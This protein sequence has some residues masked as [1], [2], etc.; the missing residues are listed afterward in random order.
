[1]AIR[2]PLVTISGQLQELPSGDTVAGSGG[3][4]VVSTLSINVPDV[5]DG[6]FEWIES[7]PGL[8][9][10]K[11]AVAWFAESDSFPLDILRFFRVQAACEVAGQLRFLI[12]A[13]AS[14]VG[15]LSIKYIL[16]S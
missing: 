3:G 5:V 10:G 7:V 13:E 8:V 15:D 11:T 9:V 12:T 4:V 14:F 2:R 6:A 16:E 1:M